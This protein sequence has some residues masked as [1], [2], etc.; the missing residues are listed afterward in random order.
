MLKIKNNK[1]YCTTHECYLEKCQ[2]HKT[3]DLFLKC[4]C[5]K[6]FE[7]GTISEG[8]FNPNDYEHYTPNYN[9]ALIESMLEQLADDDIDYPSFDF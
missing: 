4:P 8:N 7:C 5:N 1:W 6:H 3:K 9:N 2:N